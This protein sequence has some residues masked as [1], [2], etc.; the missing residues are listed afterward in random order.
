LAVSAQLKLLL[1]LL[2]SLALRSSEPVPS[3]RAQVQ[4]LPEAVPDPRALLRR[5]LPLPPLPQRIHGAVLLTPLHP[6]SFMCCCC[7]SSLDLGPDD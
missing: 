1:L 2:A 6:S 5:R 4:A 7:C 3:A